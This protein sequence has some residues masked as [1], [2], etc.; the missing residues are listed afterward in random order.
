MVT[1]RILFWEEKQMPKKLLQ[2]M[3]VLVLI[4]VSPTV[5]R[6][7]QNPEH[8]QAQKWEQCRTLVTVITAYEHHQY[9]EDQ[10]GTLK[11]RKA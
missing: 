2:P 11:N 6:Q 4:V 10:S 3:V 7:C 1:V 5:L 8:Q 9:I